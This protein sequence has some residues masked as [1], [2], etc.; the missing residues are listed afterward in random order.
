[1]SCVY[2]I[3]AWRA[4]KRSDT[5]KR[6]IVFNPRDGYADQKLQLPCG[7]CVGCSRSRAKQWTTRLYHESQLHEQNS[8]I[9][10][11]YENPPVSLVKS[12][13]QR[14]IKRLRKLH[15]LRFFAVGEYGERTRRPHYHLILFGKDY[16]EGSY[17]ID[18]N[19]YGSPVINETWGKGIA[20]IGAVTPKSIAYVAGYCNK[21]IGD[22]DTFNLMSRR[23]GIGHSWLDKYADDIRRTEVISIEGHETAV[24]ARYFDWAQLEGLKNK[25][26]SYFKKLTPDQVVERRIAN[27][28]REIN[29]KSS[30]SLK[31]E[32]I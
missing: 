24:P 13:V 25:R 8:F 19:L 6:G 26:R 22:P 28:S 14:F 29:Y 18:G 16:L 12:D 9:T 20:S 30:N 7:K 23:P 27:R 21:K 2:P 17:D 11:T 4:K 15:P 31:G 10:L 5:G 32:T 1:M 3:D